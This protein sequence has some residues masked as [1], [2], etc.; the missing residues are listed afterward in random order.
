MIS[1][2]FRAEARRHLDGKWG[3]AACISLAYMAVFFVL[4]FVGGFLPEKSLIT[5]IYSLAVY[6]I[7]IPLSFGLIISFYKLYRFEDIKAFDFLSSGFSN[8]KKAWGISLRIAL[9]LIIPIILLLVA[10]ILVSS[11]IILSISAS[12]SLGLTCV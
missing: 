6:V 1:S 2:D 12:I 9:K 5:N 7:E 11:L 10:Y 4:G 8:F 3:K